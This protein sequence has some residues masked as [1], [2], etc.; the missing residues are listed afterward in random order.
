M[1]F[2]DSRRQLLSLAIAGT[3]IRIVIGVEEIGWLVLHRITVVV[4]RIRDRLQHV[5]RPIIVWL[6]GKRF[7]F[8]R[9]AQF[10]LGQM[11][12]YGYLAVEG[13]VLRLVRVVRG[14]E[15][16]EEGGRSTDGGDLV[17]VALIRR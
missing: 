4:L 15:Y 8:T 14:A 6:W 9:A 7:F 16:V 13:N 12:R 17:I 11:P 10:Q 5:P 3:A 1:A 2:F